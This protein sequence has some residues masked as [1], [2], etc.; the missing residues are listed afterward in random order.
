MSR[1]LS[2]RAL[3]GSHA[4]P[5][6]DFGGVCDVG[7]QLQGVLEQS[8]M[9]P[10]S[11]VSGEWETVRGPGKDTGLCGAFPCWMEVGLLPTFVL[12]TRPTT[13]FPGALSPSL[14]ALGRDTEDIQRVMGSQPPTAWLQ[15]PQALSS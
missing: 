10:S 6:P 14:G 5:S 1:S 8:L 13:A 3:P 9:E 2:I 7:P 12:H 4:L 15:T 11:S